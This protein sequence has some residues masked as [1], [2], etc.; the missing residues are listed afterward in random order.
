MSRTLTFVSAKVIAVFRA[1]MLLPS[2]IPQLVNST[3]LQP[4]L[5]MEKTILLRRVLYASS[6]MKLVLSPRMYLRW[7]G[8]WW[9]LTLFFLLISFI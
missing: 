5:G 3:T 7:D 8:E 4:L 6:T 2:L 1:L 9:L